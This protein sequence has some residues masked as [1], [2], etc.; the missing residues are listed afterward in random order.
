MTRHTIRRL[1]FLTTAAAAVAEFLRRRGLLPKRQLDP[2]SE[3]EDLGTGGDATPAEGPG[4]GAPVID[5]VHAPGH[6]HRG[7]A[8]QTTMPQSASIASKWHQPWVRTTHSDS[9]RRRF[10]R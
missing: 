8:P 4:P 7:P 5:P 2:T 3:L 10:R 1:L 6:R 9:Q